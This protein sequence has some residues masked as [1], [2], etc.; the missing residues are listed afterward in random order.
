MTDEKRFLIA[1]GSP[2]CPGV[3]LRP[4]GKVKTDVDRMTAFFT[5]SEQ[6]YE[7]V[8]AN[9]IPLGAE[10]GCIKREME[11]W[12]SDDSRR[13]D[14][15]VVVYY[16][17]HGD[18]DVGTFKSHY[19]FTRDSNPKRLASTA[20]ETGELAKL[21][22]SGKGQRPQS[23]LLILDTC[24]AGVGAGQVAAALAA[25]KQSV[26]SGIGAGLYVLASAGPN[27][28]AG[29]GAFVDAFLEAVAD[30]SY[31]G[32]GGA[33]YLNPLD[34]AAAVNERFRQTGRGQ[35]AEADVVGGGRIRQMFIRN[36]TY[37]PSPPGATLEDLDHWDRKSRGVDEDVLAGD[38]FVGRTAALDELRGWLAAPETD[39]RARVVTGSPGS[40]KSAVLGRLV[41]ELHRKAMSGDRSNISIYAHRLGLAQIAESLGRQ[42]GIQEWT[43]ESVLRSL[44]QPGPPIRILVDALDEALEPRYIEDRLLVPLAGFSRTRLVVG[45]RKDRSGRTPLGALMVEIDLDS[46]AYFRQSDVESYVLRR[47]TERHADTAVEG[48]GVKVEVLARAVAQRSGQSFLY[49]RVVSRW[50]ATTGLNAPEGDWINQIPGDVLEAFGRDLD[51]FDGETRRRFIDLLMPLAYAQGKGLPQ[52]RVWQQ[53]AS[54]IAGRTYTNADIRDLKERA[55]YYITR[56]VEGEDTVYRLFHEAFAQYLRDLTRDEAVH[57]AMYDALRSSA[58]RDPNGHLEWSQVHEPYIVTYLA[59]HAAHAGRLPELLEDAEFL[60]HANPQ[61]LTLTLR[62]IPIDPKRCATAY[63]RAYS[64]MVAADV[65]ERAQYLALSA[66]QYNCSTLLDR[67]RARQSLCEWF[68]VRTWYRDVGSHVIATMR[69]FRRACLAMA[70]DNVVKLVVVTADSVHVLSLSTGE[71]LSGFVFSGEDVAAVAEVPFTDEIVIALAHENG[72]VSVLNVTQQKQ[73]WRSPVIASGSAPKICV[74][75]RGSEHILVTGDEDGAVTVWSVPEFTQVV[76]KRVHRAAITF[77]AGGSLQGKSVLMSC[78]DAYRRGRVVET[79]QVRMWDAKTLELVRAFSGPRGSGAEWTALVDVEGRVYVVTY[80]FPKMAYGL[81]EARTGKDVAVFDDMHSRP[82]GALAEGASASILSGF[83]DSFRWIR[84]AGAAHGAIGM[85]ATASVTVEGGQWLGPVNAGGR[86]AV[87]SVGNNVRVWD[88]ARLQRHASEAIEAEVGHIQ[89]DGE[90][91]FCLA[92]PAR[93]NYF[94]GLSRYGNLRVWSD[95]GQCVALKQVVAS[96]EAPDTDDFD[97]LQMIDFA[98]RC[99]FV[100]AGRSGAIQSWHLDG[101]PAYPRINIGD[102]MAAFHVHPVGQRLLA[103]VAM[104]RDAR[105]QVAVWDLVEGEEVAA[106]GRFDSE[107]SY[108]KTIDHLAA[109]E[110]GEGTILVG[111]MGHSYYHWVFAWDLSSAAAGT[112]QGPTGRRTRWQLQMEREITCM[113]PARYLGL[114]AVALGDDAGW[115]TVLRVSNGEVL[116]T[117]RAHDKRVVGVSCTGAWG[118]DLLVSAG[119]EGT[120]VGIASSQDHGKRGADPSVERFTVD[121]GDRIKA[122]AA[123]AGGRVVAGTEQGFLLF[124]LA[125]RV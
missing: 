66:A 28:S 53:L 50:L 119:S 56:D 7:R 58:P 8:L 4:L 101:S 59:V 72:T 96:L 9:E 25:V 102:F 34:I 100:T 55:G 67:L 5:S 19:L 123:V 93:S 20:I 54:G 124:H 45:T 104:R 118:K 91:L 12:F 122:I 98:G 113:A 65:R 29:D 97:Y 41:M 24:Y 117:Y 109:L 110:D 46:P 33:G 32:P 2:E 111:A 13:E 114:Q 73:L 121:V 63:L 94:A 57:Q 84:V 16:A 62:A 85:E 81:H 11:R 99:L 83:G 69:G 49:A 10:A 3:G 80:Y 6:K 82:F 88:L 37:F 116:G 52:K 35:Q 36:T 125:P 86:P 42:L 40:G 27:D 22:F 23:L 90:P 48:H 18:D 108:D 76:K 31:F 68:P 89:E 115:I 87:L 120:L 51:R 15:C 112:G 38:Y 1:I 14:D 64:H 17:G 79:K 44:A 70:P 21:F 77:L 92:A 95:E 43:L 75:G 106:T 103:F 78:S 39:W 107:Y 61:T 105:C 74:V 71:E 26:L 30:K 47:L 60:L